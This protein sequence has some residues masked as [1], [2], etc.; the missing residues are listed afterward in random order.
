MFRNF[1]KYMAWL[2]T[3]RILQ[4]LLRNPSPTNRESELI[5]RRA[6]QIPW[7]YIDF[8]RKPSR[9]KSRIRR[10]S[11][12]L[13][14][15]HGLTNRCTLMTR[16]WLGRRNPLF[17]KK[18]LDRRSLIKPPLCACIQDRTKIPTRRT[19]FCNEP[20]EH[21]R[22]NW[23]GWWKLDCRAGWKSRR[24]DPRSTFLGNERKI[25]VGDSISNVSSSA[26]SDST[27]LTFINI[28]FVFCF[29]FG[30]YSVALE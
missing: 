5:Q 7:L 27:F 26:Y 11:N 3:G 20:I 25:T 12:S 18:T 2:W 29:Y 28:G 1:G 4:W 15:D 13:L 30:D 8:T 23:S 21:N 9:S 17:S 14:Y 22:S 24:A 6:R 19:Q 10:E 16:K